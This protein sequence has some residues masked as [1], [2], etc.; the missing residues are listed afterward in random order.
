V[1]DLDLGADLGAPVAS[2]LSYLSISFALLFYAAAAI[3]LLGVLVQT[4]RFAM[5]YLRQR[6]DPASREAAAGRRRS[7]AEDA[8]RLVTEV[9]L[10]RSTFY[11]DR[12]AWIFGAFFHFGLALVLARHLRYFIEPAWIGPLWRAVMLVQPFGYYGGLLLPLGAGGYWGR[13]L[14]VKRVRMVLA[15]ADH[16]MMALLIAIPITGYA[17]ALVRTD[18]I[19]VKA[20]IVGLLAFDWKPLPAD[21]LLLV[22]LW[23]VALLMID[24]PFSRLLLLL[25]FGRLLRLPGVFE[26]E[27]QRVKPMMTRPRVASFAAVM[28]MMLI[29][30]GLAVSQVWAQG[31]WP[32]ARPDFSEFARAHKAENTAAIRYHPNF[33][34][35]HRS[36]VVYRGARA[37]GNNIERCVTCHAVKDAEQQPVSYEDPKHFCRGCHEKAAVN[38]DCFECHNSKPLPESSASAATG[39]FSEA[40]TGEERSVAR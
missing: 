18:L 38:I 6:R 12:W 3:L 5:E 24:L 4:W 14:L 28:V 37:E 2:H 21:P 33:L 10:F 25:P 27:G 8:F 16:V 11:A 32:T 17:N 7:R 40:R 31:G 39:Q 9:V 23:L 30:F 35:F 19:A 29:P 22:H 36:V 13:Q 1:D 26:A 34:M 15:P 20:F